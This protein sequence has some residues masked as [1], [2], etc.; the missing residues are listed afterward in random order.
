MTLSVDHIHHIDRRI[1]NEGE[2]FASA[3]GSNAQSMNLWVPSERVSSHW[4]EV[5]TAPERKWAELIPWMLE[6]RILHPVADMHFV[7]AGRSQ[8]NQL[9]ILAVSKQDMQEWQRIA[10]NAGVSALCMVPDFMVLPWEEGRITVGWREGLCLVRSGAT[11]G[12]AASPD[13][14]WT[15]IGRL[16]E[17]SEIAPRLSISIPDQS[18]IP[19]SLRDMADINDAAVDW[20]FTEMPASLNLLTGKFKPIASK[21]SR[22]AWLP[23]AALASLAIVL[24]F[25]YLQISSNMLQGQVQL[26]EKQ[27]VSGYT[28]LFG[29][30]NIKA[31]DVRPVG[32]QQ[33]AILFGQQQALQTGAVAGLTAL[34]QFMSLCGCSLVALKAEQDNI[35]LSIDGA[36]KLKAK[37]LNIPGYQ[38]SITQLPNAPA[39]SILLTIV[40]RGGA[41]R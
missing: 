14:A 9:H 41:G 25:A 15:M 22:S 26:L 31:S 10:D 20:V 34:D 35:T 40:P 28:K 16:L 27:V 36:S 19:E 7:M 17:R 2:A 5:P 4:I 32:E 30:G 11:E 3:A 1:T 29:A 18:L 21:A 24:L 33:I 6:D 8:D 23:A 39:D 38:T 13:I 37:A 12:F